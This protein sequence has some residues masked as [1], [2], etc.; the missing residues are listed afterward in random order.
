MQTGDGL[1]A[2][3]NIDAPVEIAA[4]SEVCSASQE[5]GNGIV[6]I[7]RRGSLQIRG[8]T[9][10]ST[11]AF[12]QKVLSLG[13]GR[14][15]A[16]QIITSP[17]LG[18]DPNEACELQEVVADLKAMLADRPYHSRL[19]PKV[20]VLIDGGGAIDLNEVNADIRVRATGAEALHVSLAGD[21]RTA[22][23]LGWV[24]FKSV[25]G[26]VD[27]VLETIARGGPDKRA[28]QLV[29]AAN[30]DELRAT[31]LAE[32]PG[33]GVPAVAPHGEAIGLHELHQGVF[34]LGFALPFG[35]MTAA[36]L[37]QFARM[38]E[39]CGASHLRPAPD[40]TLL[41]I[42]LPSAGAERLFKHAVDKGFIT[43]PKDP[44]RSIVA[45]AGAPACSSAQMPTRELA[46][47]LATRSGRLIDGSFT[48]HLSGCPKGCAHS[49]PAAITLVG[50]HHLILQGRADDTP[51]G[52]LTSDA[53]P[54]LEC[55]L[56]AIQAMRR[57]DESMKDAIV[58]AGQARVLNLMTMEGRSV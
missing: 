16:P 4:F 30:F 13:L 11:P 40:R 55:M 17:L 48:V 7:T 39:S 53:A 52:A 18:L 1:L 6:E 36:K 24:K 5:Y 23:H 31:L 20:S 46:E 2:R 54:A 57:T 22:T 43:D 32:R 3:I 35:F 44:R 45:C 29:Q 34:A 26:V 47:Q 28:R 41:A 50:P 9:E 58:R 37:L 51:Q 49:A 25:V 27:S 33:A 21:A 19:S 38:A 56:T 10:S 15:S 12:A 42:G 8:L 14:D